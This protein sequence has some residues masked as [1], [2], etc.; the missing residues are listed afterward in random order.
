MLSSLKQ[1]V[2]DPTTN[3]EDGVRLKMKTAVQAMEDFMSFAKSDQ[4]RGLYNATS[5]KRDYRARVENI[6]NQLASE[7]PAVKEAARAIFNSIL[8]YYSRDTYRAAV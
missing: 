3:I 5:L 1:M 8:K 6:I 4:V 2:S 7:D